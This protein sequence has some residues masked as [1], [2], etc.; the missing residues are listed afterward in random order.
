MGLYFISATLF[1]GMPIYITGLMSKKLVETGGDESTMFRQLNSGLTIG[2]S[3]AP[4]SHLPSIVTQ[5]KKLS[6]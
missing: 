5:Q 3:T 2:M 6:M 4:A 1:V